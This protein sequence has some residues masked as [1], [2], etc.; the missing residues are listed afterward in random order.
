[1][2]AVQPIYHNF[3]C[4]EICRLIITIIRARSRISVLGV[5]LMRGFVLKREADL[6]H[7]FYAK[8]RKFE[9]LLK[10]IILY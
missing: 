1:M 4:R 2:L 9:I 8:K 3:K 10:K 7:L 5:I 6:G